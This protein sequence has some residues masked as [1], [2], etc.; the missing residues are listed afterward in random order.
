MSRLR[1]RSEGD[2]T[3]NMTCQAP[4]QF[5]AIPNFEM[6]LNRE[7]LNLERNGPGTAL[8]DPISGLH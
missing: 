8:T 7:F 4:L 5:E 6:S 2:V 3:G 1:R